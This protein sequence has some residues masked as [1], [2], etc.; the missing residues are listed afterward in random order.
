MSKPIIRVVVAALICLAVVAAVSPSVQAGIE[1]VFRKA[2]ASTAVN[3]S[4][5]IDSQTLEQ[6][7]MN[8]KTPASSQFDDLAPLDSSRGCNSDPSADY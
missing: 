8:E 4:T 7:T 2:D 3:S 1:S 5:I 6:G